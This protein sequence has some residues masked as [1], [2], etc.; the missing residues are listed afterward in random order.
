MYTC[1]KFYRQ[2]PGDA[3]YYQQKEH[4]A[5]Q[6][7]KFC[8]SSFKNL[9]PCYDDVTWTSCSLKLPVIRMFVKQLKWTHIKVLVT[10]PLWGEFTG[11]R[12]TTFKSNFRQQCYWIA[13]PAKPWVQS[14]NTSLVRF[15]VISHTSGRS[16]FYHIHTVSK[17]NGDGACLNEFD[18]TKLLIF[19]IC[20]LFHSVAE[21]WW[22]M[23]LKGKRHGDTVAYVIVAT[24]IRLFSIMTSRGLNTYCDVTQCINWFWIFIAKH[25][26]RH[27]PHPLE[28]MGRVW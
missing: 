21:S 9:E 26:H 16:R 27:K 5:N 4:F 1:L 17:R 19:L 11:D 20:N 6:C 18:T 8:W 3:E 13:R 23:S 22:N 24:L 28:T 14:S 10:G 2:I 12:W 15:T 7:V 25:D